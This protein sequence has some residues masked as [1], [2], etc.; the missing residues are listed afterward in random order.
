MIRLN[1]TQKKSNWQFCYLHSIIGFDGCS[2]RGSQTHTTYIIGYFLF[3]QGYRSLSN[4]VVIYQIR[5][6][7]LLRLYRQVKY[8]QPTH[9]TICSGKNVTGIL[10]SVLKGRN[11]INRIKTNLLSTFEMYNVLEHK[12]GHLMSSTKNYQQQIW[13][14]GEDLQGNLT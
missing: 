2:S 3:P 9:K 6:G 10:N 4:C 13:I 7:N 1:H 14:I 5:G 8:G 11:M 12:H